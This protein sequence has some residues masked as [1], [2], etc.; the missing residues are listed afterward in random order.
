MYILMSRGLY[1]A[2]GGSSSWK[3][4]SLQTKRPTAGILQ[5]VMFLKWRIQFRQVEAKMY[6]WMQ[7]VIGGIYNGT[8]T[9][10]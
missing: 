6:V 2:D 3:Y 5:Q 1:R 10:G 9:A 8:I 4:K 7:A